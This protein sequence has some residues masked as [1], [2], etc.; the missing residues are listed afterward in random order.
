MSCGNLDESQVYGGSDFSDVHL[1]AVTSGPSEP[2]LPKHVCALP[3]TEKLSMSRC[4]SDDA[5]L[6]PQEMVPRNASFCYWDSDA[7]D[8]DSRVYVGADH[9]NMHL[10]AVKP[11]PVLQSD[12]RQTS[13]NA[14]LEALKP[15]C[16]Q[17][18]ITE[19]PSQTDSETGSEAAEQVSVNPDVDT[20]L[21]AP[22]LETEQPSL[23]RCDTDDTL[24]SPQALV[25]R[26]TSFCYWDSDA[27]DPDSRVYVN[28]DHSNMHLLAVKPEPVHEG[29]TRQCS[30]AGD[31]NEKSDPVTPEVPK[32]AIQERISPVADSQVEA[33]TPALPAP[34][35]ETGKPSMSKCDSDDALLSPGKMPHNASFCYWDSDAWDPDSRVYV[36]ADHSNEHLLAVKPEPVQEGDTSQCTDAVHVNEKSE[37]ATPEVLEPVCAQPSSAEAVSADTTAQTTTHALPVSSPQTEKPP[38]EARNKSSDFGHSGAHASDTD[39]AAVVQTLE[40]ACLQSQAA[41]APQW[42]CQSRS[43]ADSDDYWDQDWGY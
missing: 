37:P 6:S 36:G 27:W 11:E 32:P 28:A 19:K 8:P 12:T 42:E 26:Q 41:C 17:P 39:Q 13:V 43:R 10:L 33:T 24:L 3:E 14:K 18:L 31:T 38:D 29:D 5:L 20:R 34:S 35:S 2:Q 25:A 16:A 7:W 22:S 1:L 9:S 23:A 40:Q 15:V 4:D 30:N 21:A